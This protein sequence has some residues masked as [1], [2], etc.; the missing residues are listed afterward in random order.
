MSQ[1]RRNYPLHILPEH[2]EEWV[3]DSGI[4]EI[5]T[6][7]S[8]E[9]LSIPEQI[10]ELLDRN[11]KS[12]WSSWQ[13]GPGWAVMGIDYVTG[14]RIYNGAQFKPDNPVQR[15]ED[16]KP[17]FKKD[18]SPDLQKYFNVLGEETCPLFLDTGEPA[19]WLKIR[20]DA[21]RR[22]LITEGAKKAGSA[23]TAGE[24][25]ISIPGVACGQKKGVLKKDIKAFCQ[26]GRPVVLAFDSDLFHNIN[27]CRELDRLG[28][29]LSG[30][31][32][33]VR[34]LVLPRDTKGL[35]DYI[36]A[37]GHEAFKQM[38]DEAITFEKWRDLYIKREV[39]ELRSPLDFIPDVE[40]NYQ[41][42]AEAA[43]FSDRPWVSIERKLYQWTGTHY[44]HCSDS[45]LRRRI[46]D[47]CRSTPI[48]SGGEWRYGYAT[49]TVV[50]NILAWIVEAFSVDP[51]I[52]N[53]PGLNCLNGVVQIQWKGEKPCWKLV[54]HDPS[55]IYTNIGEFE[56]DPN[57]DSTACDRLLLC[58][59][60]PQREIFLKTLA[61]SLDLK[62]IRKWR[63]RSV[64][65]LL[66]KGDGN[67][68]KDS[69][70]EAVALLYGAGVV[71]TTVNDFYQYDQGRKFPLVKLEHARISWS[72]ENSSFGQLDN[73]QSLK[74][75]IT[76]DP[77]DLERKNQD[78]QSMELATIF[79]FNINNVPNMQASLEAIQSRW[80]VLSF[81][82][83]FKLNADP[84]RGE[85]EA[86]PRF[87]YDP[88]FMRR[89]V[90][91]ALLNKMLTVLPEVA[92]KAIDYSCTESA[93]Q[94][95]QEENNHLIRFAKDVGLDYQV[96]GMLSAGEI[97]DV[98][99]QWYLD[100]GYA[101]IKINSKGKETLDFPD[102]GNRR[103]RPIKQSSDVI[104]RFLEIFTKA[105]R[106][107]RDTT[108]ANG[109][110]GR[111]YIQGLGF[112]GKANNTQ[113][114]VYESITSK[115]DYLTVEECKLLI[116]KLASKIDFPNSPQP[117]QHSDTTEVSRL[118]NAS[119]NDSIDSTTLSPEWSISNSV[120]E[121]ASTITDSADAVVSALSVGN[122]RDIN[123]GSSKN[124][125][126][127]AIAD[128]RPGDRVKAK[129]SKIYGI[130]ANRVLTIVKIEGDL[131]TVTFK[132]CR[133]V[134]GCEV[135]LTELCHV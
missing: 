42:K 120:E 65:A 45:V 31:G 24:A 95:I 77:L 13:Y 100:N 12:R 85:I 115:I 97:W 40:D 98:L 108:R 18:G 33:I 30:E 14:E 59:D 116:S 109:K 26:T 70:R 87:R 68:G 10:D 130:P 25:C 75:A 111:S 17:K 39:Q 110:P 134:S 83:T 56:F 84:S 60:P 66:C 9:S 102:P 71:N 46:A 1:K 88:D 3:T 43:L 96:G 113:K 76:G 57:A 23:L 79:L 20:D 62:T 127:P 44:Q 34:V 64:R 117:T 123:V 29:L 124:F 126:S 19:Y 55:V 82:K 133:S 21:T 86:D 52:C 90:V 22:L 99:R 78:E 37:Y 6:T 92:M 106:G 101:E 69:L 8:I 35:D 5:I 114:F 67:N 107:G 89:E 50:N 81:D 121:S 4:D 11:T 51:A 103:D 105:K 132:G 125:N 122:A 93:L 104:S 36:V 74:A 2:F 112:V 7:R 53:P 63:G 16:G 32:V 15:V 28:K 58:L 73:L 135:P 38:L 118:S 91:P 49:A 27:V 41:L 48:Y 61:A 54:Q 128:F 72:S 129:S 47:W 131:A 94:E 80:A 119:T